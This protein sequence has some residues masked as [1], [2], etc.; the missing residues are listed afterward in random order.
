MT[1]H[2]EAAFDRNGN[3]AKAEPQI[4]APQPS[5]FIGS[6]SPDD[7]QY[8]PADFVWAIPFCAKP[9]D[10]IS[11]CIPAGAGTVIAEH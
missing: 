7:P 4:G 11:A 5:W 9:H 10:A 3:P 1:C 2:T 8:R 6:G